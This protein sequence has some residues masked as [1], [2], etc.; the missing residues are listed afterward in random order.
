MRYGIAIDSRMC[1]GCYC[2][3]MA[4]KDE[5]CGFASSLSAAQPMMGQHWMDLR[6]WERGDNSR[7]IKVA[8]VPTP[9]S[10]CQNPAC[11][12]AATV[13]GAVYQRED[14]IVIIDPEKAKGQKQIVDACP[15][16]AIYWNEELQLPQKCTMCAE[17]LDDPEYLAYLGDPKL[18]KPRCVEACPNNALFFGDLDDP[19][20]EIFKAI[21]ANKV[22][23]LTGLEGQETNVVHLNIPTAFLAGTVYLPEEEVA[24]GAKVTLTCKDCGCV[25]TME[26][27]YFGDFEFEDLKKDAN[28]EIVIELD[29]YKPVTLTAK[30]DSDHYVGQIVLEKA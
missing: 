29:G 30:A 7:R 12:A 10:H 4:C 2:C 17:L 27:N 18:K 25:R 15:I 23:Q 26:S 9:C 5:H 21:A 20:S 14:G 13:E 1:M 8:S 3:V 24:I 22:T 11:M 16:G 19:D 28:Y 6:E